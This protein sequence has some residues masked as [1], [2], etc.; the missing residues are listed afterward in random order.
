MNKIIMQVTAIGMSQVKLLSALNSSL[1]REGYEVHSMC[2]AD[3]YE[4]EIRQSGVIFHHVNTDRC[5]NIKNNVKTLISMIKVIRQVRPDILHV[6]TPVAAL[7]GRI[8]GRLAGVPNIIYTAHGFYFHEGMGRY[9]YSFYYLLEKYAGRLCTDYIFTQSREDYELAV[10]GG[11]LKKYNYLHISNGIDLDGRFNYNSISLADINNL[12]NKL[13]INPGTVVFS[14]LGR[15]VKEKGVLELLE[16]FSEV[17]K[18]YP[19]T[20]LICMGSIPES[21]RD[22][23]AGVE[24]EK[25]SDSENIIFTGQIASP[26]LYYAVSDVFV[27]PSYREGMPRSII[28]AMAMHNAVIATDIRGSREE[29]THGEN[30][31]LVPVGNAVKLA[32]AMTRLIEHPEVIE[33]MKQSGYTRTVKEYNEKHVVGK[34]LEVFE[35]LSGRLENEAII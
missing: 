28:E 2:T 7:L 11:F 17:N 6:H 31:L 13:D 34:Q 15:M 9:Q 4:K 23:T 19:D 3:E 16:A 32:E 30:G 35:Q 20:V 12:K 18:I 29:I 22:Q 5:I 21:E 14:F 33:Q 24:I 1:L 8:A 26:E 27:L 25:F 10:S